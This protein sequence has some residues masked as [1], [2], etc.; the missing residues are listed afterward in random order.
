MFHVRAYESRNDGT[1][2][3]TTTCALQQVQ[4]GYGQLHAFFTNSSNSTK[5]EIIERSDTSRAAAFIV[6]PSIF[7]LSRHL[8]LYAVSVALLLNADIIL[9]NVPVREA[10]NYGSTRN[11]CKS[12]NYFKSEKVQFRNHRTETSFFEKCHQR[13]HIFVIGHLLRDPQRINKMNSTL[14]VTIF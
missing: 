11:G 5:K 1:K 7:I 4:T 3:C 6:S 13:N 9:C 8:P 2:Q 10:H 12:S 14:F